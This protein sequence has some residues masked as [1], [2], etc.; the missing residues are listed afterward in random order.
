[1]SDQDVRGVDPANGG[2][3]WSHP[4][5]VRSVPMALPV[6]DD[7][8]VLA[9]DDGAAAFR[10]HRDGDAYRAEPLWST[11][12]VKGSLATPVAVGDSL[13]GYD[14]EFLACVSITDGARRWKSR[15]P[16][17]RG[18]IA[19]DGRLVI[20]GAGGVVVLA[21]ASPEGYRELARVDVFDRTG[22][23]YPTF[24]DG[25]V[26][27]RN[28]REVAAVSLEG[29]SGAEPASWLTRWGRAMRLR[30]A[31]PFHALEDRF[32]QFIR[33]RAGPGEAP[34]PS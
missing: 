17:G 2:I 25:R 16:G 31:R 18:L 33:H 15:P 10:I 8:F 20:G 6:G 22:Y 3:L 12:A 19:V 27:V 21:E 13:F 23:T 1:M 28:T 24:A 11:S 5:A 9:G 30:L 14:G 4:A 32:W 34:P 26:Y 7:E 29:R